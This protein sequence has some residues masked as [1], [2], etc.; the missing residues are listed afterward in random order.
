MRVVQVS[1]ARPA[2]RELALQLGPLE[3][4]DSP[5]RLR[6]FRFAKDMRTVL[7]QIQRALKPKG[8]AVLVIGNSTVK[9]TFLDN[10]SLVV[11]AAKQAGLKELSRYSREIPANHRYL[12]PPKLEGDQPLAK[13]IREEV[14]LTLEKVE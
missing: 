8:H 14:V 9:G 12:P 4:I 6:L 7:R 1:A 3:T 11:A 5:T 13:R 2:L 10:T